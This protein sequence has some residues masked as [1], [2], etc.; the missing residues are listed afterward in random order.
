MP[1]TASLEDAD[2]QCVCC[3][4]NGDTHIA[5]WSRGQVILRPTE[6]NLARPEEEMETLQSGGSWGMSSA[7][8]GGTESGYVLILGYIPGFSDREHHILKGYSNPVMESTLVTLKGGKVPC[9][10]DIDTVQI[11]SNSVRLVSA[12]N[13]SSWRGLAQWANSKTCAR[14]CWY[15]VGNATLPTALYSRVAA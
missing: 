11:S 13:L 14:A 9:D 5:G 7:E 4:T 12:K 3:P 8:A 1:Y 10:V 2:V 15:V 6:A